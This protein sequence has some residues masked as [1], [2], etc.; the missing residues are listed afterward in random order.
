MP[1]QENNWREVIMKDL[2]QK[3]LDRCGIYTTI[4]E[5]SYLRDFLDEVV[6]EALSLAYEKGKSDE[7][8]LHQEEATKIFE[9]FAENLSTL[10]KN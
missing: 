1:N 10:N 2:H 8:K 7:K 5:N 3:R 9:N 6:A 4:G